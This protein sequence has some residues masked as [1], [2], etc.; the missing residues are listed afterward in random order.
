MNTIGA[1][2]LRVVTLICFFGKA[3]EV[4]A[5]EKGLIGLLGGLLTK[6]LKRF[7]SISF[8]SSGSSS[9]SKVLKVGSFCLWEM[10]GNGESVFLRVRR[11][12][13][14]STFGTVSYDVTGDAVSGNCV[15]TTTNGS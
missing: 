10:V 6:L 11:I 4:E 12:S 15:E 8:P 13:G 5:R 9:S 14:D 1:D 7:K 2:S 3:G